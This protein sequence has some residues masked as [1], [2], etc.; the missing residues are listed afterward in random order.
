MIA[1]VD[2]VN[3]FGVFVD[4]VDDSV[5]SINIVLPVAIIRTLELLEVSVGHASGGCENDVGSA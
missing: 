3:S 4:G 5:R 1:D 2:D